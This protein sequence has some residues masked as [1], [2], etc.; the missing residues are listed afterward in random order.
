MS[1]RDKGKKKYETWYAFGRKQGLLKKK[2]HDVLYISTM[3]DINYTVFK[4]KHMLHCSGI[5]INSENNEATFACITR[6]D[7]RKL[8]QLISSKRGGGWFNISSTNIKQLNV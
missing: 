8:L 5:C 3:C 1:N 4:K 2:N 7:N 6:P